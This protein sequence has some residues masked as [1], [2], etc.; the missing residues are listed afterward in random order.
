MLTP[1]RTRAFEKSRAGMAAAAAT[2]AREAC[3]RCEVRGEGAASTRPS[4]YKAGREV[5]LPKG[6]GARL[7]RPHRGTRR[8]QRM[9]ALGRPSAAGMPAARCARSGRPSCRSRSPCTLPEP[10]EGSLPGSRATTRPAALA[11][12]RSAPPERRQQRKHVREA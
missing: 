11:N 12:R 4:V 7:T 6:S 5:P 8:R 10:K 1:N 9:C 2:G 3:A